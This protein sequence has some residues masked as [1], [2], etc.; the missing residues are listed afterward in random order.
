[1]FFLLCYTDRSETAALLLE[2]G[3]KASDKDYSG[4]TVLL[5][6]VTKMPAVVSQHPNIKASFGC[7]T[8]LSESVKDLCYYYYY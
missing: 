3:G 5:L 7:D 4:H 1:M 6:M 8:E 2:L